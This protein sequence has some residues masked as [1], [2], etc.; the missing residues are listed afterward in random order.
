[1]VGF[2]FYPEGEGE[3]YDA[4]WVIECDGPEVARHYVGWEPEVVDLIKV[5]ALV[6]APQDRINWLL[7]V[8][9]STKLLYGLFII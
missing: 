6:L 4:P 5:C 7:S 9:I 2:V 8:S 1:M 3:T